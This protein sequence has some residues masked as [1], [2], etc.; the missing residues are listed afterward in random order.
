M[1][2][3]TH[4][5]D[6]PLAT[7]L[8]LLCL[9]FASAMAGAATPQF[10]YLL[11]CGGCHIEDGSGMADIVPDLNEDLGY[12]ASFEEGRSYLVR[13]PGASHSPMSDGELTEVMNWMLRTFAAADNPEPYSEAEVTANRRIRMDDALTVRKQL[14]ELKNSG[15]DISAVPRTTTVPQAF[16]GPLQPADHAEAPDQLASLSALSALSTLSAPRPTPAPPLPPL[17]AQQQ[18]AFG[19]ALFF[20]TSLSRFGNQAC[21]SCHD[22]GRAFA[23]PRSLSAGKGASIGS[24]GS[25]IGHRNAPSLTYIATTPDFTLQDST[26]AGSLQP[27]RPTARTTTTTTPPPADSIRGGFFW[28]GRQATLEDQVLTPF[29]NPKEMGL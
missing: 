2:I 3:T 19:E 14:L 20:D 25:S 7:L 8:L 22:P 11:H 1:A 9:P 18:R 17:S 5:P 27:P 24:D 21:A 4:C 29:V 28:D 26:P 15:A 23:D 6:R 13:V 12:F 10:N 16:V